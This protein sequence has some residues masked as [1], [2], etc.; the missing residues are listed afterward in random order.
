MEQSNNRQ[1]TGR[2]FRDAGGRLLPLADVGPKFK[3]QQGFNQEKARLNI[4]KRWSKK[5]KKMDS[6]ETGAKQIKCC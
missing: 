1:A 4:Q 6:T 5:T 2:C 3:R